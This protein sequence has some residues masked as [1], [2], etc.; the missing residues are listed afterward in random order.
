MSAAQHRMGEL[1]GLKGTACW[2]GPM[3]T[4]VDVTLPDTLLAA[5]ECVG[6]P[7]KSLPL[8]PLKALSTGLW[9]LGE[10]TGAGPQMS[11]CC[12]SGKC[13]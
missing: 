11:N 3:R 10:E 4:G 5:G 12:C 6:A 2:S 7:S 8:Q 1:Q 13:T 9:V